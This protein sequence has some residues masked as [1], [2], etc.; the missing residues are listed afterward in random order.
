MVNSV[1]LTSSIIFGV[2]HFVVMTLSLHI[3]FGLK[4]LIIVG[5]TTSIIN[6]GSTNHIIK[7]C[8]RFVMIIGFVL[9]LY[10]ISQIINKFHRDNCFLILFLAAGFYIFTKFIY[11]IFK[12]IKIS[13]ILHILSHFTLTFLNIYLIILNNQKIIFDYKNKN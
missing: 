2:V 3:D 9:D 8:D 4:S 11:K 13:N 6:H 10:F 1:L 5:I 12:S 7:L